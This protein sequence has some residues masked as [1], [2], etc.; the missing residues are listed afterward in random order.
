M[1]IQSLTAIV[2]ALGCASAS[3]AQTRELRSVPAANVAQQPSRHA[4]KG[5][6]GGDL[7]QLGRCQVE[8]QVLPS[9]I[10]LFVYDKQGQPLDVRTARGLALLKLD[11]DAKRYRYDLFPE[12]REDKSA[13]TLAVPVD[14]TRVAG[15]NVELKFHWPAFPVFNAGPHNS[16]S[17]LLCGCRSPSSRLQP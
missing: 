12:V 7:Q 5:P 2:L 16:Q 8:P 3:S 11:G 13:H 9:G 4:T 1:R 17:V 6:H 14:L 10:R 15:Q